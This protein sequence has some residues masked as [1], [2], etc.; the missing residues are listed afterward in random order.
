ML[1]PLSAIQLLRAYAATNLDN[2]HAAANVHPD[3]V[4]AHFISDRHGRADG[5]AGTGMDI[6]HH[7]DGASRCIWLIEQVDDLDDCFLVN[8]IRKYLC[9]C[10]LSIQFKRVI[11]LISDALASASSPQTFSIRCSEEKT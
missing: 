1:D 3:K 10:I 8:V 7:S 2:I 4:W 5:A 9:G 11:L 6:G